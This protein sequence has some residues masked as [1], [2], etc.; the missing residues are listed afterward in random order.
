MKS[1]SQKLTAASVGA[2]IAIALTGAVAWATIPSSGGVIHGCYQKS[3]GKLR[4]VNDPSTC[5]DA[6]LPISWNQTGPQGPKGDTGATGPQGHT[7]PQGLPGQKGDT[8]ATGPQ[9]PQGDPG[10]Q[11]LQG[12]AGPPGP[13]GAA[14]AFEFYFRP[15]RDILPI[16]SAAVTAGHLTLPAGTFMVSARVLV[17]SFDGSLLPGP[18]E[19]SCVIVPDNTSAIFLGEGLDE[20]STIVHGN[21]KSGNIALLAAYSSNGGPS[22][23]HGVQVRCWGE[24]TT[25][26]GFT[27]MKVGFVKIDA[28]Q[29]SDVTLQ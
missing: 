21:F 13:A 27:D 11:G 6:E 15:S 12:A 2:V 22:D 10:P 23:A 9:G 3:D 20:S 25:S 24:S 17:H 8:G 19:A 29:V 4:V 5:R 18:R 28:I 1:H 14:H 7:G 26:A 16:R